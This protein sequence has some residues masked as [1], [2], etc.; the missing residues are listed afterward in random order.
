MSF[1]W[2]LNENIETCSS[3]PGWYQVTPD[4]KAI[5]RWNLRSWNPKDPG[6]PNVRG[7][8]RGVQSPPKRIV[9]RFQYH[10]QFGEP[11]SLGKV[12]NCQLCFTKK[13]PQR[14]WNYGWRKETVI[15]FYRNGTS[16]ASS[17][18]I[19]ASSGKKHTFCCNFGVCSLFFSSKITWN[20]CPTLF[21]NAP[22]DLNITLH[23]W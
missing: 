2:D 13:Y 19:Y 1:I 4:F 18:I 10:S 9:F 17:T 20:K 5:P 14:S 11:G 21:P 23:L 12:R 7:W 6:S 16:L 8:A 3:L 22:W 15:Y